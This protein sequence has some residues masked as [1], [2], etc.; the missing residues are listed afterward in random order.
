MVR[1]CKWLLGKGADINFDDYVLGT[2]LICVIRRTV[3]DDLQI[4][5]VQ[6][7]LDHGAQA[8]VQ[9]LDPF[10]PYGN[11]TVIPMSLALEFASEDTALCGELVKTLLK[12]NVLPSFEQSGI[13]EQSFRTSFW[14][15]P[16][17][18]R[19][20]HFLSRSSSFSSIASGTSISS[21]ATNVSGLLLLNTDTEAGIKPP[22]ATLM[23]C[24]LCYM[25][26]LF[27]EILDLRVTSSL[28]NETKSK[29]L[30]FLNK[31]GTGDTENEFVSHLA[32]QER[33]ALSSFPTAEFAIS[34]AKNGQ[35]H[36]IKVLIE[37]KA[38]FNIMSECLEIRVLSGITELLD[39]LLD[40]CPQ[41]TPTILSNVQKSWITAVTIGNIETLRVFLKH[42]T[43]VNMIIKENHGSTLQEPGSAIA[44]AVQNGVLPSVQYLSLLLEI[45]LTVKTKGL[46]LLHLAVLAPRKRREII[47]LLLVKGANILERSN[48]GGTILHVSSTAFELSR[49]PPPDLT[50]LIPCTSLPWHKAFFSFCPF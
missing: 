21:L 31:Y 46:N 28:N 50:R 48:P 7:L 11:D 44:H 32:T 27:K 20:D 35:T 36:Q 1:V 49:F 10:R 4:P 45:D 15:E 2:P 42:G 33:L 16:F 39:L 8:D 34:A 29:I 43:D 14:S 17:R 12:A 30:S 22:M 37:K 23:E 3:W 6:L 5:M 9:F 13:W 47:D 26:Q 25:V 18:P 38:N 24:R 40:Y 41:E 19:G